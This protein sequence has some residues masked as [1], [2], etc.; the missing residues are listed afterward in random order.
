MIT[1]QIYADVAAVAKAAARVVFE[2]LAEH[3]ENRK[4][5]LAH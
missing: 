4:F 5:L 2:R 1:I 3:Q